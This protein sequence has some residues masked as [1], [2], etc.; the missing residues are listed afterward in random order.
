MRRPFLPW[1]CGPWIAGWMLCL[2]AASGCANEGLHL[3]VDVKTD[4]VPGL[5]IFRVRTIVEDR[6][7]VGYAAPRARIVTEL[8]PS[9]DVASGRRIAEIDRLPPGGYRVTVQLLDHG[10][11]PVIER[12]SHV[13]LESSYV[14]VVIIARD[15]AVVSCPREGDAAGATECLAGRCVA[16]DC[17]ATGECAAPQCS[18][19]G[20]CPTPVAACASA[21]CEGGVCFAVARPGACREGEVCDP[22]VT[23]VPI[24]ETDPG[25]VD[26]DGDGAISGVDCDDHSPERY[27]GAGEICGNGIDESCDGDDQECPTT[28]DVD[29]DGTPASEDCDDGDERRHP[30]ATEVCGNFVDEDCDGADVVCASG[31]DA[32]VPATD[33]GIV[34]RD[35]D[36]SPAG[37]DCD[38]DDDRIHP[39]AVDVCG[40]F[41]DEDCSGRDAGCGSAGYGEPCDDVTA[42]SDTAAQHLA[43]VG[44]TCQRCCVKCLMRERFH[45]VNV[46]GDCTAQGMVWC[47]DPE[48]LDDEGRLRGGF[49]AAQWSACTE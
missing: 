49:E 7:Q 1:I 27:P 18:S 3:A 33:G 45:W 14:M 10:G 38:D 16:P 29:G 11:R 19:A 21:R 2:L 17:I 6:A 4:L 37:V 24:V 23:C 8:A 20:E 5:E 48:A 30:D 9:T 36:G 15:C 47:D 40:N 25:A 26:R 39:G 46:D 44:G 32:G 35:G 31:R 13:R 22:D 12:R 28:R 41:V 43:C 34:D 42:C